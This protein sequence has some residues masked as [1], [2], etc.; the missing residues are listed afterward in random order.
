MSFSHDR[1][2]EPRTDLH[3]LWNVSVQSDALGQ[4]LGQ[5]LDYSSSGMRIAVDGVSIVRQGER[6]EIQYPG[7]HLSYLATVAWSTPDQT[8]TIIG[9]RL[10]EAAD[11]ASRA[12]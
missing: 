7:T 6:L 4:R 5:V 8:K 9:V 2:S 1:R 11:A 3:R 10:L 12:C